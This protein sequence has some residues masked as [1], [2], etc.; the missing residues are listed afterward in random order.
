MKLRLLVFLSLII[1][2]LYP[3]LILASGFDLQDVGGIDTAGA[4]YKHL[5]HTSGSV[6]FRGIAPIGSSV[7][8]SVDEVTSTVAPNSDGNWVYNAS[9]AEGDHQVS[10]SQ[11]SN[12]ISFTLTIGTPP[13]GI[14]M[15][16]KAAIP[17]V[18]TTTPTLIIVI[19]GLSFISLAFI[20]RKRLV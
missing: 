4:S 17:P 19:S 12:A 5:W 16:P 15:P 9:L 11:D 7:T 20:L 6:A 2:L 14:G 10:F 8:V 1:S 13:A 18:G 3:K